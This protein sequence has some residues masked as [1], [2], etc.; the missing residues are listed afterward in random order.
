MAIGSNNAN[1]GILHLSDINNNN[2]YY[3]KEENKFHKL[4][5]IKKNEKLF[6]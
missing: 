2:F 1:T 5:P 3:F 4:T 6:D